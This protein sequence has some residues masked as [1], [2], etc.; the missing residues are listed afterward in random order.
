MILRPLSAPLVEDMKTRFAMS[1]EELEGFLSTYRDK[2]Y[3]GYSECEK[4][5]EKRIKAK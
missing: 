3:L 5:V 4:F 2:G 1:D